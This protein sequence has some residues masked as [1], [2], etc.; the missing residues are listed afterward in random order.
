MS[1]VLSQSPVTGYGLGVRDQVVFSA[2]SF[3]DAMAN[4]RWRIPPA[5][6]IAV[7]GIDRWAADPGR[8]D[9]MAL[10]VLLDDGSMR[11]TSWSELR[12][13]TLRG[14]TV[15]RDRYGLDSGDVVAI[16]LGQGLGSAVAQ[17]SAYRAGAVACPISRLYSGHAL[18]WRLRHSG[19]KVLITDE[20]G[21]ESLGAERETIQEDLEVLVVDEARGATDGF[22]QVLASTEPRPDV[23]ADTT[24]EDPAL[25]IYTSGTTGNPKGVLH[26]HRVA[27]GHANV[28]YLLDEVRD[29]DVFWSP[30]DW[31]WIAGVGN[32]LLAPWGFGTPILSMGDG[33]FDPHRVAEFVDRHRPT[34]SFL[35][36]SAL[37]ILRQHDMAFKHKLRCVVT[38]GEVLS[39]DLRDWC[40]ANICESI[41][42]GFGQTE[43][44]DLIGVV[45]RWQSPA[46]ETIGRLLPGHVAAVLDEN[47][48]EVPDGS[49]GELY[50][51]VDE[52]PVFMLRYLDNPQE[53]S[54]KFEDGWLRT[55]DRVYRDPSGYFHFVGRGDDVIKS[56]GYRIG[57]SEIENILMSHPAVL[58]CAVVGLPDDARGQ[59]V[60]A[61][62]RLSTEAD[63]HTVIPELE[64][65]T[66]GNVGKHA[67]PR[68]FEILDDFPKTVTGKIQRS[69]IRD[70]YSR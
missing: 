4:H 54:S 69:T 24:A 12:D 35:P 70:L 1:D 63:R 56:S 13:W 22:W 15:L 41:N 31:S 65:L 58:E 53:T 68:R 8:R 26:G 14:A 5:Y 27:L 45:S 49:E 33:R 64:S 21:L 61:V 40:L 52:R 11:S 32:G 34:T 60:T 3:E 30:N 2:S 9:A 37:R 10:G 29:D 47:G 51:R 23:T 48:E 25:L 55:G 39:D 6:N 36:P 18:V 43:G 59:I 50:L 46:P 38:G 16:L 20:M 17:Y 62:V 57:P 66:R 44:N 28:S 7:D 42:I 67:Y 19:A